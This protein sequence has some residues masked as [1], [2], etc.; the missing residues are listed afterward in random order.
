MKIKG[1]GVC[2]CEGRDGRV[3]SLGNHEV[4][5]TKN[6]LYL[7]SYLDG[8]SN[9]TKV[10]LIVFFLLLIILILIGGGVYYCKRHNNGFKL[11]FAH[12]SF[13]NPVHMSSS[14]DEM[15]IE[16]VNH[17]DDEGWTS[18]FGSSLFVLLDWTS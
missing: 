10:G 13:E 11:A 9:G 2:V 4:H 5:A 3:G 16:F 6:I 18:W 7:H 8:I 14:Q 17:P 15:N 12:K 1:C